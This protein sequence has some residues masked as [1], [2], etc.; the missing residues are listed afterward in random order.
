MLAKDKPC[1]IDKKNYVAVIDNEIMPLFKNSNTLFHLII[2][3]YSALYWAHYLENYDCMMEPYKYLIEQSSNY[4]NVYIYWLYDENFVFDIANYKDLTHYHYKINSYE[5]DYIKQH[6]HIINIK[7]YKSKMQKF[8]RK[9]QNFDV[10][11]YL[12]Q[13]RKLKKFADK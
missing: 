12:K 9:L 6:S 11:E 3:P 5:L 8:K 10:Q 7:N 13:I 4:D 1:F 2:P